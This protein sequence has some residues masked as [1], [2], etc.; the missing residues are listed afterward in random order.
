MGQEST[1]I[2]Y[3]D[4]NTSTINKISKGEWHELWPDGYCMA[5]DIKFE[6]ID[7]Y[8]PGLEDRVWIKY[9]QLY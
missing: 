9:S 5:K 8:K 1:Y 7:D 3:K 6:Y 2:I 4:K